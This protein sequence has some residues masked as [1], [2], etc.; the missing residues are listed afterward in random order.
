LNWILRKILLPPI[1]NKWWRLLCTNSPTLIMDSRE[2]ITLLFFSKSSSYSNSSFLTTQFC[3]SLNSS[4]SWQH[5]SRCI[6]VL[7]AWESSSNAPRWL[8]RSSTRRVAGKLW[9]T[10]ASLPWLHRLSVG[11]ATTDAS[12]G[13]TDARYP[14]STR[15]WHQR[16][17]WSCGAWASDRHAAP[18]F[19]RSFPRKSKHCCSPRAYIEDATDLGSESPSPSPI[20]S[21]H[22]Y[23]RHPRPKSWAADD[24]TPPRLLPDRRQPPW[25]KHDHLP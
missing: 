8:T 15:W 18:F 9:R 10:L 3:I 17:Q 19:S 13:S 22:P 14:W 23:I 25:I 24:C 20:H 6:R 1:H 21:L 4:S 2:S 5:R 7:R 16:R 12:W 11:V